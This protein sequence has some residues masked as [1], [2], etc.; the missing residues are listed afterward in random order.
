MLFIGIWANIDNVFHILPV[1]YLAGKFVIFWVCLG[2]FIDMSTGINSS[3]IATSKYYRVQ[4]I[5]MTL[6]VLIIIV[7]NYIFIPYYNITGAGIANAISLFLFNFMRWLFLWVKFDFQPFNYKYLIVFFISAIAYFAG[8]FL[9]KLDNFIID[10]IVRS[11][12]IFVIFSLLIYFSKVSEDINGR[13]KA[14]YFKIF[15]KKN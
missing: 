6:F 5:F 13:V 4:S 11:S 10:I 9:P 12:L 14:Y 15:I 1:N 7:T 3:I 2:S 8:Y